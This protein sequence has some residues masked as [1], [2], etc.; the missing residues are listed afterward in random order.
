LSGNNLLSTRNKFNVLYP[1]ALDKVVATCNNIDCVKRDICLYNTK[2]DN[3]GVKKRYLSVIIQKFILLFVDYLSGMVRNPDYTD[4]VKHFSYSLRM[5]S[6]YIFVTYKSRCL[7][8]R[9]RC[10][11]DCKYNDGGTRCRFLFG[12]A[13]RVCPVTNRD[14]PKSSCSSCKFAVVSKMNKFKVL[15]SYK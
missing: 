7:L 14:V 9:D 12:K 3:Y 6:K 11:R 2:C 4:N 15:C 10:I 13:F 5:L 8:N 1:K